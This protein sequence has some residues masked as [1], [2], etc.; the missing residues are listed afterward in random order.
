MF[1]ALFFI[2]LAAWILGFIALHVTGSL[3]HILLI[4]A[5]FSVAIHVLR[6]KSAS[7]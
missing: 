2:L 5:L 3:I 6:G 7:V 4:I 1:L